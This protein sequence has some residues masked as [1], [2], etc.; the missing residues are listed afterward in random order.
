MVPPALPLRWLPS[1]GTESYRKRVL[2]QAL[3]VF[4]VILLE[5]LFMKHLFLYLLLLLL[6]I[7][8]LRALILWLMLRGMLKV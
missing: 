3:V 5:L 4:P 2:L 1:F 7:T 8:V 6:M